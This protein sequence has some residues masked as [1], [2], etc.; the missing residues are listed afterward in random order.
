MGS[1]GL[2][3]MARA[4]PGRDYLRR[5][6]ATDKPGAAAPFEDLM[7]ACDNPH[8]IRGTKLHARGRLNE[9]AECYDR[10]LRDDPGNIRVYARKG[11]ALL[12]GG[13]LDEAE[14]CC[15]EAL[16]LDPRCVPALMNMGLVLRRTG[17]PAEAAEYYDRAIE[18]YGAGPGTRPDTDLAR[19]YSNK[20]YALLDAGRIAEALNCCDKAIAADPDFGLGYINKGAILYELGRTDEAA[21]Y[22]LTG[23]AL[24]PGHGQDLMGE[25]LG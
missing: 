3:G 1:R 15:T 17:R 25:L 2:P 18:G 13:R 16:G 10:A 12:D 14:E 7:P 6:G 20:G 4:G 23:S 19:L 5:T 21:G 22:L 24:D 11:T 8:Y 9:A